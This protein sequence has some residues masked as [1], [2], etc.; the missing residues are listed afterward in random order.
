MKP[1]LKRR[2]SS[3]GK[4]MYRYSILSE[5]AGG[6]CSLNTWQ[7][8]CCGWLFFAGSFPRVSPATQAEREAR[9]A[10]LLQRARHKQVL[11]DSLCIAEPLLAMTLSAYCLHNRQHSQKRSA[12][13]L[14]LNNVR[15]LLVLLNVL[16]G[17]FKATPHSAAGR[18]PDQ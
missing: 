7:S 13:M 14:I 16:V 15:F 3:N 1:N 5:T 12:C 4:G 17:K 9:R 18:A 8:V 10:A 6:P 11:V 2:A